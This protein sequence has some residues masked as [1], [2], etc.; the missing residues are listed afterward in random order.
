MKNLQILLLFL[1]VIS[2]KTPTFY[3]LIELESETIKDGYSSNEDIE[4]NLNFWSNNGTTEYFI[5][6]ISQN[7]IY[8]K[9]DEC[10]IIKNGLVHDLFDNSE[11]T[12]SKGSIVGRR[13]KRTV[14]YGAA[15]SQSDV[16][17][18]NLNTAFGAEATI[19][20]AGLNAS[21]S[22]SQAASRST[23]FSSSVTTK[24]KRV[25]AIHPST[26]R[27][28][29]G[30]NLQ[31]GIF[32]DCDIDNKVSSKKSNIENGL[33]FDKNDT[34]LKVKIIVRY[35]KDENFNDIKTYELETYVFRFSNWNSK[36]FVKQEKFIECDDDISYYSYKNVTEWYSPMRYYVKYR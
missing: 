11:Y 33:T 26:S 10:Q 27:K 4:L 14:Q 35:S 7:T 28:I 1:M 5:K 18:N 32:R 3:Q 9:F 6:N 19:L 22:S 8:I 20:S 23:S 13:A 31:S 25:L 30:I 34:P 29:H 2:C 17:S 24:D 21:V 16:Y 15:I 36:A 12:S